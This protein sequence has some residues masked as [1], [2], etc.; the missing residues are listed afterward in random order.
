MTLVQFLRELLDECVKVA[1]LVEIVVGYCDVEP[2]STPDAFREISPDDL[3][4]RTTETKMRIEARVFVRLILVGQ[5][6]NAKT[7]SGLQFNFVVLKVLPMVDLVCELEVAFVDYDDR[8]GTISDSSIIHA[9][10]PP[11]TTIRIPDE[12]LVTRACTCM[13]VSKSYDLHVSDCDYY[14]ACRAYVREAVAA[15]PPPAPPYLY[16]KLSDVSFQRFKLRFKCLSGLGMGAVYEWPKR[17][18]IV[19]APTVSPGRLF[20]LRFNV[21][22]KSEPDKP[23]VLTRFLPKKQPCLALQK[24][25]HLPTTRIK[26]TL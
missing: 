13:S 18:I 25:F 24:L 21:Q 12:I 20:E 10:V 2:V 4:E 17:R 16:T 3:P 1:V 15:L 22:S 26:W 19:P 14:V 6:G 23:A 9:L 7:T 11:V 5:L 8:T